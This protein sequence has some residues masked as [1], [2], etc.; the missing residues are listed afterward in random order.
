MVSTGKTWV[1]GVIRETSM[2]QNF[3]KL[4]DVDGVVSVTPMPTPKDLEAFY[5]DVYFQQPP[6]ATYSTQYTE[7]ELKQRRLR[8]ELLLFAFVQAGVNRSKKRS[9]LEIGC[10]EGFLLQAAQNY[11]YRVK[12]VDFSDVGLRNF[13]P[14]LLEKVEIGDARCIL[15][16]L[17]VCEERF[18]V[19]AMINVLEHVIDPEMLLKGVRQIIDRDGVVAVTVPNDF[20]SSQLKLMDNGLIE[21]EFWFLPP[22]HLHYFNIDSIRKFAVRCGFD[23]VDIFADFPIDFFLFHPGSNYVRNP[24][25]G[26]AAHNARIML[27]LLLAEQGLEPYYRFCQAMSA[28]GVGRNVTVLL[29]PNEKKNDEK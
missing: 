2:V 5:A 7:E 28:C 18:A 3:T 24:E 10:G 4:R 20:S 12:G 9:F 11:G 22:Q 8:A 6:S 14:G 13:H 19:C 16:R 29:R 27:D 25:Q 15:K 23:V 1:R 26:K 17:L 21:H